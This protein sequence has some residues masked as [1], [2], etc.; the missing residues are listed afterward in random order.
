MQRKAQ[1]I[2]EPIFLKRVIQDQDILRDPEMWGKLIAVIPDEESRKRLERFWTANSVAPAEK[3]SQI[4][5]V[6]NEL[7]AKSKHR[8]VNVAAIVSEI[9]F[10]YSYPRLD[11]NVTHG[12]GHLLK[13]PFCVHPKTGSADTHLLYS[14]GRVCVPIDPTTC[15]SFDPFSVPTLTDLIDELN[16]FEAKKP[17]VEVDD[18]MK[19]SLAPYIEHFRG[20][21][22]SLELEH[23]AV[24][25]KQ[26]N[27]A[28]RGLG[29]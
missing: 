14:T 1:E 5:Q 19:T 26:R 27:E 15:E 12:L 29:F 18:F 4:S 2:L 7:A 25:D 8:K 3:W 20:F 21:L 10:E 28:E 9:I 22:K 23:K 16:K 13:S 24:R 11:A 6:L 17:G